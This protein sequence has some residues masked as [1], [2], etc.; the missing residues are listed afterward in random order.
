M[1]GAGDLANRG[2][3]CDLHNLLEVISSKQKKKLFPCVFCNEKQSKHKC[4]VR[5]KSTLCARTSP[6]GEAEGFSATP[7]QPQ[8]SNPPPCQ[9]E[10]QQLRPPA[11]LDCDYSTFSFFQLLLQLRGWQCP[12]GAT[13][14][15]KNFIRTLFCLKLYL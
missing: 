15:E 6:G 7:I 10:P 14:M 1:S 12:P 3:Q 5:R 11:P 8:A 13:C 9:H 2:S 4:L